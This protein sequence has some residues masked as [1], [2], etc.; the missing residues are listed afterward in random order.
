MLVSLL[1]H[2]CC[3]ELTVLSTVA[4]RGPGRPP[5]P[6]LSSCL[7]P[8]QLQT[9]GGGQEA[10][11]GVPRRGTTSSVCAQHSHSYSL[12]KLCPLPVLSWGTVPTPA[13]GGSPGSASVS[14]WQSPSLFQGS[15]WVGTPGMGLGEVEWQEGHTQLELDPTSCHGP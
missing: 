7:T 14:P 10:A 4:Q 1:C 8:T 9:Y 6:R 3:D 13:L 5:S 12:P 11:S 2:H 15:V